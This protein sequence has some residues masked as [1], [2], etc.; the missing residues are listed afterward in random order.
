MELGST[1]KLGQVKEG[2]SVVGRGF[3]VG[4]ENITLRKNERDRI[5]IR[6]DVRS[7]AFVNDRR[8]TESPTLTLTTS[9]V[10]GGGDYRIELEP[11]GV[12]PS[13]AISVRFDP[14]EKKLRLVNRGGAR[15]E[16]LD[17]SIVAYTP[18]GTVPNSGTVNVRRGTG[19]TIRF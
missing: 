13:A 6:R 5:K 8:G 10:E 19:K 16:S 14:R 9:N 4:A 15:V 11:D 12:N 18:K 2:L 3:S 1:S 17:L 7:F